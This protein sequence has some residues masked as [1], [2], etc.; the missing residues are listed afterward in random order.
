VNVVYTSHKI[1]LGLSRVLSEWLYLLVVIYVPKR[2][3][4]RVI[5]VTLLLLRNPFPEIFCRAFSVTVCRL[6]LYRALRSFLCLFLLSFSPFCHIFLVCHYILS[7]SFIYP[8][9]IPLANW[10]AEAIQGI[11][12]VDGTLPNS[13]SRAGSSHFICVCVCLCVCMYVCICGI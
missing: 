7:S 8:P 11:G 4:L 12:P 3:P 10:V 6:F 1:I 13:Y 9:A 5:Y 2:F